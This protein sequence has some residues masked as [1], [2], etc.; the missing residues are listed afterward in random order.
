MGLRARSGGGRQGHARPGS[1]AARGAWPG[2]GA[3]G[4][5]PGDG[6]PEAWPGESRGQG[7]R[8][9]SGRGRGGRDQGES[10]RGTKEEG[11]GRGRER[12][13]VTLGLDDRGNRPPD[14][15]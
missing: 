7:A 14:H 11:E 4:A 6:R 5:R 13:K 8:S 3:R 2:D 1:G 9:G 15:T 10:A 12:G